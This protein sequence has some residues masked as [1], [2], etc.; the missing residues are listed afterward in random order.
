[1]QTSKF[2]ELLRGKIAEAHNNINEIAQFRL[3]NTRIYGYKAY[4]YDEGQVENALRK[5]KKWQQVVQ[6]ILKMNYQSDKHENYIRFCKSIES[7]KR[8]FDYKKELPEEYNNGITVLEGIIESLELLE[9]NDVTVEKEANNHQDI[10]TELKHKSKKVFISHS[11]DDKNFAEALVDLL[12]VMGFKQE[13]IFCSSVPGYWIGN[14]KDFLYE[15]KTHFINYDLFVIFIHSPRFYNSHISLN[16]MG[17][18]WAL[19]SEYCSFLTNDMEYDKMDAVVTSHEIAIKVNTDETQSRLN[20][21][22]L[23][24]LE[25]FGKLDIDA[26]IWER[27]RNAFLEIVTSFT[28]EKV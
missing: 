19:Q 16:E 3:V 21:W 18:A 10:A 26:N 12:N 27:K 28:Y 20:D 11:S 24:I 2:I 13:E 8:G 15:I 17:A 23:R 7:V 4:Y 6:D 14:G 5:L 25:W 1:M 22:K 9:D